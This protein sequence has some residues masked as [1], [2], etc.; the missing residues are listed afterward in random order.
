MEGR[1]ESHEDIRSQDLLEKSSD[2]SFASAP[3]G[4]SRMPRS[5]M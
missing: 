3:W 1:S 2:S 4:G 5:G